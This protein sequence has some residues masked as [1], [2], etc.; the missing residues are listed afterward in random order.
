M[1]VN[2]SANAIRTECMLARENFPLAPV[3]LYRGQTLKPAADPSV[4]RVDLAAYEVMLVA[5]AP[6]A[7]NSH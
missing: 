1:V 5:L 4:L 6:T 3:D 2:L 7:D